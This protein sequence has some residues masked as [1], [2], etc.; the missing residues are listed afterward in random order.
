MK[1]Y[2]LIDRLIVVFTALIIIE[3]FMMLN[4]LIS[5][6]SLLLA[7]NIVLLLLNVRRDKFTTNN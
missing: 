3:H 5:E 1:A 7:F 6:Q 2:I 4:S